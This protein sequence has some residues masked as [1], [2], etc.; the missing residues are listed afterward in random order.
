MKKLLAFAIF[1]VAVS[2]CF[3]SRILTDELGRKVVLPD[4][5]HRLIC[6]APSVVD[7]VYQLGAGADVIA[8]SDF[9]KYPAEAAAKPSIGLPQSPSIEKILSLHPDLVLGSGK[10]NELEPL[11]P[12]EQYGI[13]VFVVDPQGLKGIYT[14]LVDLG[15]AIHREAEAQDLVGRLKAREQAVRARGI[16]KPQVRVFMPIWYDPVVTIGRDDYITELIRIAGARS[17]TDDIPL[18]WPHISMETV[19]ARDPD[20]L[21]LVRGGKMSVKQFAAYPG[22]S[23]LRAVQTGKVYLVDDRIDLPSPIVFDALE[24]LARQFHP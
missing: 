21:L 3:A 16:G 11:R 4:H 24:D 19:I 2:P 14:S 5:P 20:A 22:W 18:P 8:V 13:P 12:L 9:T 10:I 15:K 6:L 23:T 17:V 1:F 7:D